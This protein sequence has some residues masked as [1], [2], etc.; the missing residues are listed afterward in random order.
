MTRRAP[1]YLRQPRDGEGLMP[2]VVSD[3]AVIRAAELLLERGY[4]KPP[5]FH[6]NDPGQ[7]RDVLETT[8]AQIRDRLGVIR[9]L[10]IEH[11]FDPLALPNPK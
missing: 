8:D 9:G 4:G 5:A 6:T 10:L 7:F 3:S 2:G 1:T 11:G